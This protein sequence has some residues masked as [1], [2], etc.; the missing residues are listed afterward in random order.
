MATDIT[1]NFAAAFDQLAALGDKPVPM[2]FEDTSAAAAETAATKAEADKAVADAAAAKAEADKAAADAAAA[3]AEGEDEPDDT[4]EELTDD[5]K[6]AAAAAAAKPDTKP[7]PAAISDR[8][9]ELLAKFAKAVK[10][11]EK[12]QNQ[13]QTQQQPQ[14]PPLFST[15]EA[16]FLDS[17]NKD[18]PDVARAQNIMMRAMAHQVTS[19]IYSEM[20]KVLGPKLQMLDEIA[21]R[22]HTND[23]HTAVQDYD[24][25]RDKVIDWAGKQ[26]TYLREA[27]GRVISEGTVDEVAD[28]ISRYRKDTGQVSVT[29][30][31]PAKKETEL[32]NTA[33]KAAAA[34]APVGSK[35][36]AVVR[37]TSPDDFDGAFADFAKTL[38]T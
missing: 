11:D 7:D 27:Y 3:P 6:A 16:Q 38:E 14:Q 28:L 35:R 26:P 25:V 9:A 30:P 13:Q 18:W 20:A 37:Q 24:D 4:I 29:A 33:K 15:E 17:Y 22:T 34:L 36:S 10:G 23:L 32:S 2:D 1:E 31:A 8:E 21:D 5:E 12:P 19:H